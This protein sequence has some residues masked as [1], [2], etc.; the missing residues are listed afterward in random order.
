VGDAAK[1]CSVGDSSGW[2]A[3]S[4]AAVR[5]KLIRTRLEGTMGSDACSR[6]AAL[7]R[8]TALF[9]AP[10]RRRGCGDFVISMLV[11][12]VL[13]RQKCTRLSA[14]DRKNARLPAAADPGILNSKIRI[15]TSPAAPMRSMSAADHHN[16]CSAFLLRLVPVLRVQNAHKLTMSHEPSLHSDEANATPPL[17][18][19]PAPADHDLASVILAIDW[20]LERTAPG[21]D[22]CPI[23]NGN[24]LQHSVYIKGHSSNGAPIV[25]TRPAEAAMYNDHDGIVAHFRALA[26]RL[27]AAGAWSWVFDADGLAFQ[28]ILDPRTGISIARALS[29]DFGDSVTAIHVLNANALLRMCLAVVRPFLNERISSKLFVHARVD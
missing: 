3:A 16:C 18:I 12:P 19:L 22:I 28:H 13:C 26:A 20:S 17:Q 25:Y 14:E 11:Q 21:A 29:D 10:P 24:P 4:S 2:N 9:R 5:A 8:W 1:A 7:I 15:G 23:C 27:H 6:L